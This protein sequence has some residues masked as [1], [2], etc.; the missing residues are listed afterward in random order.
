MK[1]TRGAVVGVRRILGPRPPQAPIIMTAVPGSG[2]SNHV[3]NAPVYL[4]R[5]VIRPLSRS[6]LNFEAGMDAVEAAAETATQAGVPILLNPAPVA[7]HSP[8]L[9]TKASVL[10]VNEVEAAAIAQGAN[11]DHAAELAALRRF[12]PRAVV[13][14]GAGGLV[15]ADAAESFALPAFPV[16]AV[17]SVGAGDAF[18]AALG[19]RLC[20]GAGLFEAA[21]FAAAA[22]ALAVTRSGAQSALPSREEVERFLADA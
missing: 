4:S 10:V 21:R 17:D 12:A 3:W 7:P 13:T 11:G 15:A 2:F 16:T 6:L 22:G 14:L 9:L 18:C 5:Q 19:V 20:E 1:P 8:E